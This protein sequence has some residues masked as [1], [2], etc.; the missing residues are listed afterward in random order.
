[1]HFWRMDIPTPPYEGGTGDVYS[2][3]REMTGKHS[4]WNIPCPPSQGG[5]P[6]RMTNNLN[7]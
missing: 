4:Q 2:A 3:G 5:F 6:K 7:N 1:M